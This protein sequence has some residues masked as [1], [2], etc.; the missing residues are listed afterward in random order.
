MACSVRMIPTKLSSTQYYW[1][2]PLSVPS[3]NTST[4]CIHFS[5]N[6]HMHNTSLHI[7]SW[8]QEA[9]AVLV[10]GIGMTNNNMASNIGEYWAVPNIIINI[11]L[12]LVANIMMLIKLQVVSI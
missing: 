8:N 7:K 9:L 12:I 11:V 10:L 4:H 6:V 1:I 5:T 2:L 3:A